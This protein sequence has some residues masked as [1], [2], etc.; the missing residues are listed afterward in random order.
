MDTEKRVLQVD[1]E[2][3]GQR[4]LRLSLWVELYDE[5]GR[6]I[7]KF[8]GQRKRT[9]PGTSVRCKVDLSNIPKGTYKALVVADCGGDYIF[10]ANYNLK[11]E[12]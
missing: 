10:G 11:F 6:Y 2:N 1:L 7:G 9:Y 12:K 8:D 4:W 3:I 5:S